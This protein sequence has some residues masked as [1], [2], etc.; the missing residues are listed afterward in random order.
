[1]PHDS[2]LVMLLMINFKQS[3]ASLLPEVEARVQGSVALLLIQAAEG[4]LRQTV[5]RKPVQIAVPVN[6]DSNYTSL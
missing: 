3:V 1:M 4:I 2:I 6:L 5:L